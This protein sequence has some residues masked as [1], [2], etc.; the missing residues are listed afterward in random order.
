MTKRQKTELRR[1]TQ[2]INTL[3]KELTECVA[4]SETDG[5]PVGG[6]VYKEKRSVGRK[7]AVKGWMRCALIHLYYLGYDVVK[8]RKA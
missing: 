8:E 7:R 1:I 3:S 4:I 6:K 2:E 5:H